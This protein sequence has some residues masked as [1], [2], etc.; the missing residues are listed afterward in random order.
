MKKNDYLEL[1]YQARKR[2]ENFFELELMIESL[3]KIYSEISK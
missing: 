2:Y 1:R 3:D